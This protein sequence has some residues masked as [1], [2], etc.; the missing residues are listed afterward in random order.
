MHDMTTRHDN[1]IITLDYSCAN[2]EDKFN[3]KR[4]W[5]EQ[6]ILWKITA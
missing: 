4:G 6:Y 3:N 5:I 2:L 1:K